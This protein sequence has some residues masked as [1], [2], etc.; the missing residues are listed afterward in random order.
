MKPPGPARKSNALTDGAALREWLPSVPD[1]F[2]PQLVSQIRRGLSWQALRGEALA[3]LT[4]AIIALPLAMAIAIGS[5]ASPDKGLVTAIIA[6]FIISAAGGSRVQIGGPTAAFVVVVFN[7]IH[8]HGYAGMI[9]AT[10]TA[11]FMLIAA[12]YARLGTVI[13]FVPQPVVTGF[14]AGIALTIISTQMQFFLGLQIENL[15]GD[16]PHRWQAY[17]LMLDQINWPTVALGVLTLAII[18]GL[19]RKRPRWPGSLVAI[20]VTSLLVL[21]F[22]APIETIAD[23]FPTLPASLPEPHWPA[24]SFALFRKILPSAFTIAF[25]AGIEALLSAVVADGMTGYRHRSNQELVGVGVANI[26]S[27]L[28]GGLPATGAIA[29]TAANI[30]AGAQTPISGMIHAV[31][32]LAVFYLAMPVMGYVPLACLAAVLFIVAAR[33][34]EIDRVG[35][36][37]RA[38]MGDRTTLILTFLLTVV[39]DLTVAIAVGVGLA[40]LL[41]M[42]RMANAVEINTGQSPLLDSAEEGAA[43]G[44]GPDGQPAAPRDGQRSGLAEGIEVYQISGPFFFGVAN[45]LLDTLGRLK[46]PPQV[47]ILRM[48]LVPMLDASGAHALDEFI[49]RARK[50]GASVILSGVQKQPMAVLQQMNAAPGHSEIRFASDFNNAVQLAQEILDGTVRFD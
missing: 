18:V 41:F 32:L 37:L 6:G 17:A 23:R 26:A 15:P 3:G 49:S 31:A 14:T 43:E 16:V 40:S 25:L 1:E 34:S 22:N 42:V 20:G 28:W 27:S 50:L 30:R 29:R 10:F 36:L 7:I 21:A 9:L 48:R 19:A 13:K 4:V 45:Q 35:N 39:A 12:G 38:P 5:G 46:S 24:F 47:F 11:G 8:D 33:M 44:P 2:Q